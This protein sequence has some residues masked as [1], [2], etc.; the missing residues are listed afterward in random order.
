[1]PKIY[2]KMK[3]RIFSLLSA[4]VIALMSFNSCSDDDSNKSVP[5]NYRMIIVNEGNYG[6]G[7]ADIS[8]IGRD[9]EITNKVFESVNNR[10]LGDV[11]QSATLINEKL[12]VT[13]NNSA[14]IEVMDAR[15]FVQEAT[16]L[17]ENKSK[18]PQY[19]IPISN[20]EALVSD[21][22]WTMNIINTNTYEWV[23]EVEVKGSSSHMFKL[24]GK[25]LINA[26]KVFVFDIAT[27]KIEKEIDIVPVGTAKIVKDNQGYVWVLTQ[28]ALVQLDGT[29]FDVKKE[30]SFDNVDYEINKY[31]SR[32]D[33]SND[34]K[35]LYFNAGG[36]GGWVANS[37]YKVETTATEAPAESISG[38]E[39]EVITLYNFAVSPEGTLIVC[40][41][42]DY[43]QS[44]KVFEFDT[45]GELINE[46]TA[47]IIPQYIFFADKN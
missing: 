10:P 21:L 15:T 41:V 35:N 45:E 27:K 43:K 12:Y 26:S 7:T 16:I 23:S 39:D 5:L 33:I 31:A 11:G 32:L 4:A 1:M 44:G 18:K 34:G 36:K 22:G 28:E 3:K 13:L 25:V 29:T 24:G 14:K 20:T 6:A 30:I 17:D 46:W 8:V 40:D 19:V 2:I 38:I 47:G 37:M 42:L 9:N